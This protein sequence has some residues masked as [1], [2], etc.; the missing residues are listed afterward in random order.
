MF[1]IWWKEVHSHNV[2]LELDSLY[3]PE[4]KQVGFCIEDNAQIIYSG[5]VGVLYMVE[6]WLKTQHCGKECAYRLQL[7][8]C[9]MMKRFTSKFRIYWAGQEI[10]WSNWTRQ[11]TNMLPKDRCCILIKFASSN[12][13]SLRSIL[14]LSSHLWVS[15][16]NNFFL[17]DFTTKFFCVFLVSL[18]VS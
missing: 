15:T 16:S 10:L 12:P 8:I 1:H 6:T 11:L 2:T 7:T 3:S 9:A 4:K 5:S 18:Y 17:W 13:I 14:I